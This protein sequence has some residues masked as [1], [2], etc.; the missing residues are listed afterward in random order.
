MYELAIPT[1]WTKKSVVH[2]IMLMAWKNPEAP[3]FRV[4]AAEEDGGEE[5]ARSRHLSYKLYLNS[6][7]IIYVRQQ[8]RHM[9]LTMGLILGSPLDQFHISWLQ[10]GRNNF[11]F[12]CYPS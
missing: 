12:K 5:L 1:K 4:V 3:V 8:A 2:I 11:V 10:H 6:L 9:I 7:E